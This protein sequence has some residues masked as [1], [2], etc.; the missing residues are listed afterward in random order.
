MCARMQVQRS[1]RTGEYG[2]Q[3]HGVSSQF[4]NINIGMPLLPLPVDRAT[5]SRDQSMRRTCT[6]LI[7]TG[8]SAVP[9]DA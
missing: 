9:R 2:R 8:V 5:G 7:A 3:I 6:V 1:R 4:T